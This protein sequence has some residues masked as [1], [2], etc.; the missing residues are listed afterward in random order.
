MEAVREWSMF[1]DLP[2][3]TVTMDDKISYHEEMERI[4]I[5]AGDFTQAEHHRS[6]QAI[7]KKIKERHR[8]DPG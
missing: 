1:K 4:A 7:L 2:N 5:S 3:T 6:L 8:K